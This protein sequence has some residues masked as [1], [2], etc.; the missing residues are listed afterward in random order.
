LQFSL[1]ESERLRLE[2]E[3]A[4]VAKSEFLA[5]M[6]HEIRTPMN[7]VLGML[8]L[9]KRSNLSDEQA[10]KLQLAQ[11][12]AESLLVLINDILD[13]SKI[14]AG[15][16]ELEE[17]DFNLHNVLGEF[18]ESMAWRAQEQGLELILDLSEVKY[19][20]VTGDPGRLRQILTNLVGNSIKFTETG[21]IVIHA[22]LT[23]IDESHL[24]LT[25]SV[26]DTGIASNKIDTL[27][28]SFTQADSSTT[29]EY[30][31]TGLGLSIGKKLCELMGGGIE[32]SSELGKG[33]HFKFDICLTMSSHTTLVRP[34]ALK[35][36]IYWWSKEI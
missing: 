3:Q 5:S 17:L 35:S 27:F 25:C 10:H 32:V 23:K 26:S 1:S 14:D 24:K 21:E 2:A 18:A 12:S 30:G 22:K 11:S 7:G 13:F 9:L 31:G 28:D 34:D 19:A 33:S 8:G 20:M 36:Y 29:R 15:K 16:L 4:N 6:S